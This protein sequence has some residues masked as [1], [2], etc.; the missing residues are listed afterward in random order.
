MRRL[1]RGGLL[2]KCDIEVVAD[3]D[4]DAGEILKGVLSGPRATA[5]MEYVINLCEIHRVGVAIAW[6]LYE[7]LFHR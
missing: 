6:M 4:A 3:D 2:P 1:E 5:S 7:K